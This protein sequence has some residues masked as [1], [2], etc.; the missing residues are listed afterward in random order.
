MRCIAQTRDPRFD[1]LERTPHAFSQSCA[2]AGRYPKQASY[3]EHGR[4]GHLSSKWAVSSTVGKVPQG[5]RCP[6][7]PP[8]ASQLHPPGAPPPSSDEFR[9]RR[10]RLGHTP[11]VLTASPLTLIPLAVATSPTPS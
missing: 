1:T 3:A 11:G 7:P 10:L 6:R 5:A 2:H 4:E 8:L 9:S